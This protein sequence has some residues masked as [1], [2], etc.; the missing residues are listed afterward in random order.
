MY[1]KVTTPVVMIVFNRFEKTLE[2]FKRVKL[3]EPS[4]LY[5]IADG[6]RYGNESDV[7]KCEKVRSIFDK[8][9]WPCD[10]IKDYS[11][12][13]LGCAKR[14]FTGIS[15]VF[16]KE[17][18][19]IILED[20]CLPNISF[21]RYCDEML[22]KYLED[23]RV[24]LVSGTNIKIKWGTDNNTYHFSK[25]GGIHGWATWKRSW[26]LVD[27]NISLWKDA[28]TKRLLNNKLSKRFYELRSS[29]Y[30]QLVDNSENAD[31]W[32]YQFGFARFINNGLAIVPAVNLISNIGYDE[33]ST[34]NFDSNSRTANLPTFSLQ[35]PLNHPKVMIEDVQYDKLFEDLLYPRTFK[36]AIS[37]ILKKLLKYYEKRITNIRK[38]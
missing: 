31:T 25:L 33:E 7:E 38:K 8:I 29:I 36:V 35:F 3:M 18:A 26:D 17:S 24:M 10:V 30:D 22:I 4:K 37:L 2:V 1:Y 15:N 6:P 14:V 19:A 32:D 12:T 11:L 27:I 34:H 20:D 13:N 28:N 21:F 9:Q 5:I 16:S 23:E